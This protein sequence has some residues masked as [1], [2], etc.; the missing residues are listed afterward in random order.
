MN[1]FVKAINES[2]DL[3]TFSIPEEKN[4]FKIYYKV[5]TRL[6]DEGFFQDDILNICPTSISTMYFGL[7]LVGQNEQTGRDEYKIMIHCNEDYL[8]E[9]ECK[10]IEK[11]LSVYEYLG[12]LQI[13][14]VGY[15]D[16]NN[17]INKPIY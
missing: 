9:R 6:L 11:S 17:I 10:F 5:I 15:V 16:L 1:Y 14:H 13:R 2:G 4:S 8:F 7:R 12:F 3:L